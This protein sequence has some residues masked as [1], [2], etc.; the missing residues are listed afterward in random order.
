MAAL[1]KHMLKELL[2]VCSA[3]GSMES[4]DDGAK[5]RFVRGEN[6]LEWLQDL[7][8]ALR[9][10]DDQTRDILITLASW[11]VLQMKLIPLI[12]EC[13]DDA[14]LVKTLLKLYVMLTMPMT[15][16]TEDTL[17]KPVNPKAEGDVRDQQARRRENASAQQAS[18]Q[19]FK[20]AFVSKDV[21]EV[22][23]GVLE[24]P[25][26]HTGVARTDEDNFIMELCLTLLR[27]ILNIK[28]PVPGTNSVADHMMQLQ[29]QLVVLFQDALLLD[30]LLLLAQ[31]VT[32]RENAKLNLLLVEIFHSILK[33]QEPGA[34]ISSHQ[35]SLSRVNQNHN[36]K[37]VHSQQSAVGGM[38]SSLLT[39]ERDKRSLASSQMNSRHSRFGGNLQLGGGDGAVRMLANPFLDPTDSIPQAS[40]K[41][42]KKNSTFSV[43]DASSASQGVSD[44]HRAVQARRSLFS[45]CSSFV[46]TAY[47]PFMRSIKV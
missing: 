13:R 38:L 30:I 23:V 43:N 16:Q 33:G 8:R 47:D 40:R 24:E 11:K 1:E 39:K 36:G 32:S 46:E 19:A 12:L 42:V 34:I 31:D 15:K 17:L 18:L 20:R 44:S 29:E 28:D 22:I 45:F 37:R 27:N 25:L 26:S 7:Q 9:R 21:L 6:C 14:D 2:L 35:E 10:D 41:K 4:E 3:L 5:E